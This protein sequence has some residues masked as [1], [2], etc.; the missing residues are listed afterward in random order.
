MLTHKQYAETAMWML[1]M[2]VLLGF[3]GM[4]QYGPSMNSESVLAEAK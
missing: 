2:F 3:A 4:G 1:V